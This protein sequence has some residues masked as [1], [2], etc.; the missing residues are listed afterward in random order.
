[1]AKLVELPDGNQAEFPDDM[2][3]EAISA[4]L[5][6]QFPTTGQPVD[7]VD[8]PLTKAYKGAKHSLFKLSRGIGTTVLPSRGLE[9]MAER[10]GV[11]PSEAQ[12]S[13][14]EADAGDSLSATL[15]GLGMDV[16]TEFLPFKK[17]LAGA[18][19]L[20]QA[21][22]RAA[23]M[24]AVSGGVRAEGENTPSQAALGGLGG[25][26]GEA[27]G[28]TIG[29]GLSRLLRPSEN[30]VNLMA[31]G[32]VPT[33][34]QGLDQSTLLGKALRF[35]EDQTETM[36][37]TGASIRDLRGKVSDQLLGSA[38]RLSTARGMSTP[39]G[40]R[41]EV[42]NQLINQGNER[43]GEA[44]AN[45]QVRITPQHFAAMSRAIDDSVSRHGVS[46]QVADRIRRDVNQLLWAGINNGRT[47]ARVLE[48]VK[49]D[50]YAGLP[51]SHN[52]TN[53][54]RVLNDLGASIKNWVDSAVGSSGTDL[55]D[56]R[57]SLVNA[58]VLR[59]AGGSDTGLS[60][61]R[62]MAGVRSNDAATG[63]S[64]TASREMRDLAE[65]GSIVELPRGAFSRGS[66]RGLLG[67]A[68]LG[69][70]TGLAGTTV[71]NAVGLLQR[72]DAVR[73]LLMGDKATL[74][75]LMKAVQPYTA[76]AGTEALTEK[77]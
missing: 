21:L 57:Q 71:G 27:G 9:A 34:G 18:T 4:V 36:P 7:S 44:L 59:R 75:A 10:A 55:R 26:I 23:A 19:L 17:A 73:R 1:M 37:L 52:N 43:M 64:D 8:N 46:P 3:E 53:A 16:A 69:A 2:S 70:T 13:A 11:M 20:R 47:T 74:D 24:G 28:R 56:L 6:K 61:R 25:A 35:V 54:Q 48:N 50:L 40:S 14:M 49:Q 31:H 72:P 33:L 60:G 38:A 68:A 5:R 76:I 15:G 67:D 51:S 22:P 77:R 42:V 32:T 45:T 41:T 63:A 12:V 62:L 29:A 39:Q 66:L 58:H 65:A 30:A